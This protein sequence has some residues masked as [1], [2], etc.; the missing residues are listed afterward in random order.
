MHLREHE[1]GVVEGEHVVAS[2]EGGVQARAVDLPRQKTRGHRKDSVELPA[3]ELALVA[4][5]GEHGAVAV[6]LIVAEREARLD[7]ILRI[8]HTEL[9][10]IALREPARVAPGDV[11]GACHVAHDKHVLRLGDHGLEVASVVP[12]QMLRVGSV[13]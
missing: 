5:E 7:G 9:A 3:V 12:A 8:V 6:G 11:A 4:R 13:Y 2:R 10:I 1:R